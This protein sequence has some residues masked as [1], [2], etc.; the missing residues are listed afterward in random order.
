MF[1]G[2]V[3]TLGTILSYETLDSSESGGN[4]VSMVIGDAAAVLSDVQLGDSI[5]TNGVCLT[6]TE[7]DDARTQFKVGVSPETLRRSNLG[8]LKKGDKVDLE[9]AVSSNTRMGGHVV[10]GHVDTIATITKKQPENNAI[11]FTF[12]LRDRQ[13]I[14]YIVE[15]GFI[16][17]DGASLTVTAV[18]YTTAEFS[19]QM[20]AYTQEK[21]VISGKNEG[22]TVNIEVDVAGK[23]IEKQV[24]LVLTGMVSNEDS[25]V[26][27]ALN[28]LIEKKIKELK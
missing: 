2:I 17:V 13:Y 1:T 16:C 4:G 6:V 14:N 21:V 23:L 11:N 28:S 10:Q 9:R 24:E 5:C 22:N 7:F 12:Q 15:K 20:V 19:I 8:D 25:A 18:D 3:E 26:A 27:K